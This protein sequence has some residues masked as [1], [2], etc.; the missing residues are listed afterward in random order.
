MGD[1]TLCRRGCDRG[2]RT[3]HLRTF[4]LAEEKSGFR[5]HFLGRSRQRLACGWRGRVAMSDND[6]YFWSDDWRQKH[7]S[8]RKFMRRKDRSLGAVFREMYPDVDVPP[9]PGSGDAQILGEPV[10]GP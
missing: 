8:R 7:F 3:S 2:D 5:L 4:V 1:R 9:R 10:A 6:V